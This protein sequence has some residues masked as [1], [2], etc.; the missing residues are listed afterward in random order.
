MYTADRMYAVTDRIYDAHEHR[1]FE[2]DLHRQFALP[3]M[4]AY[5]KA[6]IKRVQEEHSDAAPGELLT[7]LFVYSMNYLLVTV[8]VYADRVSVRCEDS[9]IGLMEFEYLRKALRSD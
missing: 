8:R 3:K 5:M 4:A 7:R 9:D 2:R 1:A 6:W